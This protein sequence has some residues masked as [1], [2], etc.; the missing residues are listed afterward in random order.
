[1]IQIHPLALETIDQL[2]ALYKEAAT[3]ADRVPG[4]EQQLAEAKRK[5]PT[6]HQ[7][8]AEWVDKLQSTSLLPPGADL[9]KIARSLAEDNSWLVDQLLDY[10]LPPP[11]SGDVVKEANDS[12]SDQG[13]FVDHDGWLTC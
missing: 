12:H 5:A 8:I 7:K 4:L 9:E 1:M 11:D 10:H 13:K 6:A 3:T 2:L